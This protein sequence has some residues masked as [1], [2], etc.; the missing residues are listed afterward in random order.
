MTTLPS[1][2][3]DLAHFRVATGDPA[4]EREECSPVIAHELHDP[5]QGVT[6]P[7]EGRKIGKRL[8]RAK[9]AVAGGAHHIA[10]KAL[11]RPEVVE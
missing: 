1:L 3:D 8:G 2:L 9:H 11:L 5:R 10:V 7:V 4:H 6:E